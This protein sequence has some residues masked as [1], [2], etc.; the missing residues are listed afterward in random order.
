ME[1]ILMTKNYRGHD[2]EMLV[3]EGEDHLDAHVQ[4][5]Q[6]EIHKHY[7]SLDFSDHESLMFLDA[8]LQMHASGVGEGWT[9]G[10][11][12]IDED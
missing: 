7:P 11:S 4:C 3:M 10:L 1:S 5:K 12:F 2:I 9:P 6:C 8:E